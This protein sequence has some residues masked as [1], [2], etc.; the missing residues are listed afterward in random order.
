MTSQNAKVAVA[1]LDPAKALGA[2]AFGPLRFRRVVDGVAGDWLP[3]ATLVRLPA[4]TELRCPA[5]SGG[6]MLLGANLFLLDSI[7]DESQFQRPTQIPDGF[8]GTQLPVPRPVDG[9][10]YL[11]LR[12]DPAVV[13]IA[14][15]DGPAATSPKDVGL[16]KPVSA[17]NTSMAPESASGDIQTATVARPSVPALSVPAGSD[18]LPGSSRSD[19]LGDPPPKISVPEVESQDE[20][21]Q[22]GSGHSM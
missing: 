3:L 9:R 7:S 16:G 12:D 15:L 14:T 21:A 13:S 5:T 1:T 2:S 8:T 18:S 11:K 19:V 10:L 6:C 4:L 17:G 20:P 22:P